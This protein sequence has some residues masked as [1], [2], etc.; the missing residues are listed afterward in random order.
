MYYRMRVDKDVSIQVRDGASLCA[1]VFRPEEP[2]QFPVIMTLGPYPKDI[3]FKDWVGAGGAIDSSGIP[4]L[5]AHLPEKGP[6][7][8]WETV[9]PEWWVPQGY[10][11]IR[12]DTRGTGKSPG[13]PRLL[14][15]REAEDFYDAIEWA[16]VQEWSNS[17]VA[18]MGI[19]YFAMSAWRVAA[20]N[21]PHLAAVV[22]W[23]GALDLFRDAN[24][25]G[26]IRSNTFTD[27]WAKNVSE[28][29][30][31]GEIEREAAPAST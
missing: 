17:K 24:R 21:P 22:P 13:V 10:V 7:M 2:G 25:H 9:N 20:L 11:V 3:H 31:T 18:V 16:G 4:P 26:G 1:D 29:Q 12:V 14:T 27:M 19:S 23:E 28:H 6:Y 15:T 8:H 30:Q 5:Y